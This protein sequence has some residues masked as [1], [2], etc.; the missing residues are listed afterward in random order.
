MQIEITLFMILLQTNSQF[1]SIHWA[2]HTPKD[3]HDTFEHSHFLATLLGIN[4][5]SSLF[6]PN[7]I[8]ALV[9]STPRSN[10]FG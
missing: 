5:L 4:V 8:M 3:L 7:F 9:A 6:C 1:A 10:H 2:S